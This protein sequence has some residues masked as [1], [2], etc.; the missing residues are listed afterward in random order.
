MR[1]FILLLCILQALCLSSKTQTFLLL[2]RRWSKEAF[3][4]DSVTRQDLSNGW[5]PIYKEELDTLIIF[6]DKLKNLKNDGLTRKFY[7]SDDF[8]GPNLKLVIENIKRAYGDGYEIN[9][10]SSGPFGENT[11]KL[12]NSKELLDVNQKTIRNF[13]AYLNRTKKNISKL[14]PK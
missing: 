4:T 6:V 2:D 11:I 8:K 5:Y 12:A 7:Y 10:I 13:L 1:K 9:L 3:L 14:K